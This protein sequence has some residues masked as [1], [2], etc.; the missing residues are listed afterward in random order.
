[1]TEQVIYDVTSE[2]SEEESEMFEKM[3]YP[4]V[5]SGMALEYV[6]GTIV[7]AGAGPSARLGKWVEESGGTYLGLDIHHKSLA[8]LGAF[9]LSIVAGDICAMPFTDRSVDT[10][11]ERFVLMHLPEV[12]RKQAIAEMIRIARCRALFI[13]YDWTA[14]KGGS[15]V[16]DLRDCML[17]AFPKH[18][19]PNLG[20]R[21]WSLVNDVFGYPGLV[22]R[23]VF[24]RAQG[25]NFEELILL[26][27]AFHGTMRRLGKPVVKEA[28][29]FARMIKAEVEK[30]SP[31]KFIPPDIVVVEVNL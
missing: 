17:S 7:D 16:N 31:V 15:L 3:I 4:S 18:T 27:R 20:G 25:E 12:R 29:E 2:L 9:N 6:D 8:K 21:L 19:D 26:A 10:S 30:K 24:S 23:R 1:M 13:E 28:A 11:H 14:F 5:V 22:K